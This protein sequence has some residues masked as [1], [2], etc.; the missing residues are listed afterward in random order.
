MKL[1]NLAAS[2]RV[3]V[4]RR[5]EHENKANHTCAGGRKLAVRRNARLDRGRCWR[6]LCAP[7]RSCLCSALPRSRVQLGGR[8]LVSGWAASRLARRLLGSTA[9][10]RRVLGSAPLRRPPLLQRVLATLA[11]GSW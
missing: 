11:F 5:K 2:R 1:V 4:H 7:T 3:L 10:S 9:L 6:L 8:L